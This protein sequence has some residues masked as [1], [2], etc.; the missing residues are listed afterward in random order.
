LLE[1]FA[2]VLGHHR[3]AHRVGVALVEHEVPEARQVI[4]DG[5]CSKCGHLYALEVLLFT[6]LLDMLNVARGVQ[7]CIDSF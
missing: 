7:L 1:E 4:L 2:Q 3:V 6:R 5:P